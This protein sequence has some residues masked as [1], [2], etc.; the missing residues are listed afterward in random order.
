MWDSHSC[1]N[2]VLRVEELVPRM[3]ELLHALRD[4][5]VTIIH[6]PSDCMEYYKD[7]PGRSL[8]LQTPKANNLPPLI[9]KWCYKIPAEEQSLYPLDQSDGGNDDDPEQNGSGKRN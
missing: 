1:K 9:S 8:A 4:R 3:N 2:A 6:S 5:G 7:H